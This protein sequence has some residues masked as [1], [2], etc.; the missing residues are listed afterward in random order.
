MLLRYISCYSCNRIIHPEFG[1]EYYAS[2]EDFIKHV[3]SLVG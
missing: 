2:K 1:E 3:Y